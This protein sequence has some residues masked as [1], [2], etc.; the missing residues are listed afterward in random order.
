VWT[1][2][3]RSR[4]DAP[5]VSHHA[6]IDRPQEAERGDGVG[7]QGHQEETAYVRAIGIVWLLIRSIPMLC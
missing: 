1:G 4:S 2:D 7:S 3:I 6:A 5:L